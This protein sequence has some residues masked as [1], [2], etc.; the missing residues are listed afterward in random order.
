MEK[1]A[2]GVEYSCTGHLKEEEGRR[3]KKKVYKS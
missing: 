3:G 1:C 2:K